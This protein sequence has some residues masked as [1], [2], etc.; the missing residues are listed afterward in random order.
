MEAS[1]LFDFMDKEPL[2][3][4]IAD[5]STS[6]SEYA[7]S[8]GGSAQ[9]LATS[10][11]RSTVSS[12]ASVR[13]LSSAGSLASQER[14]LSDSGISVRGSSPDPAESSRRFKRLPS[15]QDI[16]PVQRKSIGLHVTPLSEASSGSAG[17]K[18]EPGRD[19]QLVE[20]LQNQE[21]GL[22][23]HMYYDSQPQ[24]AP[25]VHPTHD[26]RRSS[27]SQAHQSCPLPQMSLSSY[28]TPAPPVEHSS[29]VAQQPL[30]APQPHAQLPPHLSRA[31]P[32]PDAP[33]LSKITIAGYELL[34]HKLSE[35][36]ETRP[37]VAPGFKPVYR[38]FEQLNH[39]ILLH[40]QDEISELEEELRRLDEYVA[41][42]GDG[43]DDGTEDG[44]R[45]APSRRSERRSENPWYHSRVHLLGQIFMKIDQY[46]KALTS[47]NGMV[48]SLDPARAEDI[49]LYQAWIAKHAPIDETETRF[50]NHES[51]LLC[52]ARANDR[53][54]PDNVAKCAIVCLP[55]VLLVPLLA[56]SIIPGFLGR[57]FV[58][59]I[60]VIGATVLLST[61]A[62]QIV[63]PREWIAC[64]GIYLATMAIIAATLG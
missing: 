12:S 43:T 51:D 61:S 15:A 59:S 28:F 22:R 54:H 38:K 56:F 32:V 55:V 62:K 49:Q 31:P 21:R 20:Q 14:V 52:I 5:D 39:R 23:Q 45:H 48:A 35:S 19:E 46:N 58:L 11:T 2:R 63:A 34:A 18:D 9:T 36:S 17:Y 44:P 10:S 53:G 25:H 37:G 3:I 33:D 41:H 50:L 26:R 16:N 13:K 42:F 60:L 8:D 1:G 64:T 57:L 47:Y 7:G 30:H 24:H 27:S 4:N 29:V 6:S 40:L